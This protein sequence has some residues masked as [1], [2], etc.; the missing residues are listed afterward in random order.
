ML[1][2]L[3]SYSVSSLLWVTLSVFLLG[4]SKGGFPAG[5]AALPLLVLFWPDQAESARSSVA[6]MLPLLC[7]MDIAGVL[8]YRKQIILK[9]LLPLVPGSLLGVLIAG[10]L[11][12]SDKGAIISISDK[13]MKFAIALIS[14]LFVLYMAASSRIFKK[15][16]QENPTVPLSFGMGA[17]AGLTSTI[18][19][20]AAPVIQMYYLPQKLPKMQFAGTMTGY[21]FFINLVKL[22]PFALLG[23]F[24][25]GNLMLGV[26]MLPVIPLGVGAGYLLVRLMK[27]KHYIYLIY[28]VLVLTSALLLKKTFC[29]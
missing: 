3:T 9:K 6:F 26:W 17:L 29:P 20:Q 2:V 25:M 13:W 14:L 18:A 24:T 1:Q 21:F 5:N 28:A 12:V 10:V 16:R 7:V 11:F 8:F 15:W 22:L 23:R 4:T 19:H 27:E